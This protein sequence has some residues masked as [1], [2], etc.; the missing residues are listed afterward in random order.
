VSG[1]GIHWAICKSAPHSRQITTPAPHHSVFFTG[2][3]PFLL[4]NQQCQ[5]T[6]GMSKFKSVVNDSDQ[7]TK[8]PLNGCNSSSSGSY[9]SMSK[10]FHAKYCY[11]PSWR[12]RSSFSSHFSHITTLPESTLNHKNLTTLAHKH[13]WHL[14][15]KW[16]R[17]QKVSFTRWWSIDYRYM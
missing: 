9:K 10:Q 4:P 5:S 2:R 15:R 8:R 6:E 13:K 7:E 11:I 14:K 16:R 12:C 1:S 3:M 17:S